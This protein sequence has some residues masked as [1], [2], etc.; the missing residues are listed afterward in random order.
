MF[1]MLMLF[2]CCTAVAHMESNNDGD[3]SDLFPSV[4]D[5]KSSTTE[6]LNFLSATLG[7][8]MVLQRAPQQA[9]VW[10][11]TTAGATVTTTFNGKQVVTKADVN[12]TWRQVLPATPASK[13]A[14]TLTF[15]SSSGETTSLK[16]VLFGDVFICGGQSNMQFA[17]GAITNASVEKQLA[18][19]YPTIRLFTVGQKTK[20]N[21]PLNDLQTIEQNWSVASNVSIVG[22]GGFGWFSAVCWIFGRT[23]S[24]SLSPTGDVPIGLISNNWGGTPVESWSTPDAYKACNR[25]GSGNLYNAMINPYTVGPMAVSGFTWY[26]GEANTRAPPSEAQYACLFPAMISA[27]RKGFNNP[28][29]YFGFI[30]LSTW[31]PGD[32]LDVAT[33]RVAQMAALKL[34]KVGYATNADHG[35]GCNIH[36]PPKQYCGI[37]LGNS[38]L[39]LHYNKRIAWKSPSYKSATPT[40]SATTITVKISLDDVSSSG[41]TTDIY[42]FNYLD[43]KFNCTAQNIKT[44]GTCAWAAI[45]V[46]GSG[47]V[48]ATVVASGQNLLLTAPVPSI[49]DLNAV[50]VVATAYGWGPIPL[51]NAYDKATDLPVLP[52]NQTL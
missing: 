17:M 1:T 13:K 37:R 47:W 10:G 48:N 4:K 24:D 2:L 22:G 51:M 9:V 18:N 41:L 43:G 46:S 25:T 38:A 33:M 14:Y 20:S 11:H 5:V 42:P 39:A 19:N 29:A 16:D 6:V 27:W 31:C 15:K 28:S 44:P 49:N 34:P 3:S 7:D 40:V 32:V 36:P 45:E 8:H 12:G 30:Q 50:T 21:T 26:Q 52:W 35:A 23:I